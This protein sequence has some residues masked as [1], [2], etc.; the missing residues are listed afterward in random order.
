M[1]LTL[2]IL[3]FALLFSCTFTSAQ[4]ALKAKSGAIEELYPWNGGYLGIAHTFSVSYMPKHRKFQ[5]YSS[6]GTSKWETKITPF[7]FVNYALVNENSEYAYLINTP[8]QKSAI[9]ENTSNSVFLNIYQ[10]NKQGR[11]KTKVIRF[12]GDFACLKAKRGLYIKYMVATK[13]GI[14]IVTSDPN[15]EGDS[16]LFTISNDF[17][18]QKVKLGF[19]WNE[20]DWMNEDI[21]NLNFV[22]NANELSII[23]VQKI[24]RG[25]EFRVETYDLNSLDEATQ[26]VNTFTLD[27][28][29]L[30]SNYSTA[31]MS[32]YDKNQVKYSHTVSSGDGFTTHQKL[33]SLFKYQ[34]KD[35]KIYAIGVRYADSK[36]MARFN[37]KGLGYF[38]LDLEDDSEIEKLNL[39]PFGNYSVKDRIR[40]YS[41]EIDD[42]VNY[43]VQYKKAGW[44]VSADGKKEVFIGKKSTVKKAMA[45]NFGL[46]ENE[47]MKIVHYLYRSE[48]DLT[49][50]EQKGFDA[51]GG[52]K[53][54]TIVKKTSD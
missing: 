15:N 46:I 17:K 31:S 38:E 1:K 10:V 50:I 5:F 16:Y 53:K 25:L 12:A 26:F 28:I 49:V 34:S 4:T 19:D 40:Y 52:G 29:T 33:G 8:F 44:Y 35:D 45:V 36:Q 22:N 30:G 2:T 37:P 54:F 7:N 6:N 13:S 18:T 39:V 23:Q 20:E 27:N 51:A 47:D 48:S 11:L 42:K 3:C 9:L 14:S 41:I 21:S 32:S 24:N 43:V